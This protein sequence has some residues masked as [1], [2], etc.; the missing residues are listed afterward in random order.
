[1]GM[2]TLAFDLA[3]RPRS[4]DSPYWRKVYEALARREPADDRERRSDREQERSGDEQHDPDEGDSV[5]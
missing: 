4:P 2:G 5:A 1:M 3:P